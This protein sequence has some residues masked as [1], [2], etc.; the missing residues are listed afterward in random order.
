M[1]ILKTTFLKSLKNL[2]NVKVT[3]IPIVN[4]ALGTIAKGLEIRLWKLEENRGHPDL[5]QSAEAVEYTDSTS[6]DG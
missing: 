1:F 5:G 4:E 2:P 3:M 6:P